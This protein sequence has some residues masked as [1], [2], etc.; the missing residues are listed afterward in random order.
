LPGQTT[1]LTVLR[2]S[3]RRVIRVV[4]G[5]RPLQPSSGNR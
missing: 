2:G 4:L 5:E 3:E 1:E